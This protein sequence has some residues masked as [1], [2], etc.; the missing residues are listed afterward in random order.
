MQDVYLESSL[1]ISKVNSRG[2]AN[3]VGSCCREQGGDGGA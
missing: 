3:D 1:K 2:L